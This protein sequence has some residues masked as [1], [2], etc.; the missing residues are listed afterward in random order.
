MKIK[1]IIPGHLDSKRFPRKLLHQIH[2]LP[3]VEHVR[4]RAMMSE[5]VD[6]VIVA[7]CDEEISDVVKKFGGKVIMTSNTH[8]NGTSRVSEAVEKLECSHVMLL[9]GDEPLL[10]PRHVDEIVT[11]V[12]NDPSVKLWNAT[13]ALQSAVELNKNSFVKCITSVSGRILHCFRNSPY[14]SPFDVQKLFV[15][16]V[17]GIMVFERNYLLTVAKLPSSPIELSESIEQMRSIENDIA[18]HSIPVSPA[19]PSV[20]EPQEIVPILKVLKK[21]DEQ[22]IILN[23]I[24]NNKN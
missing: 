13:A 19:L 24:L 5:L 7:T 15:Q 3:M 6:D 10:L 2:G 23:N 9:Q 20:N 4:R 1:A 12:R 22:K 8:L 14:N 17:L 21:D 16:K 18:V 11:K